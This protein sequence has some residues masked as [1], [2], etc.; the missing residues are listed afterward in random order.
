M[1]DEQWRTANDGNS[2][3]EWADASYVTFQGSL[4]SIPQFRHLNNIHT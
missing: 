4:H 3:H 2:S 1:D